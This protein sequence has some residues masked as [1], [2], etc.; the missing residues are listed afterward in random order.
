VPLLNDIDMFRAKQMIQGK[1]QSADNG[2]SLLRAGTLNWII[3]LAPF[4]RAGKRSP[5]ALHLL[6]RTSHSLRNVPY[7]QVLPDSLNKSISF[8]SST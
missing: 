1:A 2:W 5:A 3:C 7:V 8:R 4:G 6:E